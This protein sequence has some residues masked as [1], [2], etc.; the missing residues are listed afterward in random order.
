MSF[1]LDTNA[2][3]DFLRRPTESPIAQQLAQLSPQDV[4]TCSVVRA[5]LVYGAFR[6]QH[7]ARNLSQVTRLLSGFQSLPFDDA[8]ADTCARVRIDLEA[9]GAQIGPFD[10]MIASI[11]VVNKLVLVTHNIDEFVRLPNLQVLD[12]QPDS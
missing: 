1:L 9:A 3:V 2:W 6:S 7:S 12:W 5:E 10:L 11:A 4:F 8:A